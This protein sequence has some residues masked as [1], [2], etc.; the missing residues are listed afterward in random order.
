MWLHA[1][2]EDTSSPALTSFPSLFLK[3]FPV[4]FILWVLHNISKL[5]FAGALWNLETSVLH[6]PFVV[7]VLM[8][9]FTAQIDHISSARIFNSGK[10]KESLADTDIILVTTEIPVVVIVHE[11]LLNLKDGCFTDVAFDCAHLIKVSFYT[12]LIW[13]EVVMQSPSV[14]EGRLCEWC[15][16]FSGFCLVAACY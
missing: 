1:S 4:V 8:T 12:S 3:E 5:I 13:Q 6:F 10:K 7:M 14:Y 15:P 2:F 16:L 9:W 11:F